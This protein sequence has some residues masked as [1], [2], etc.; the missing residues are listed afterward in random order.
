MELSQTVVI[1]E[2]E[3]WGFDIDQHSIIMC[4]ESCPQK[5]KSKANSLSLPV[6]DI[7]S[8]ILN[9]HLLSQN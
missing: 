4:L 7:F 3:I 2:L 6:W 5:H 9:I 1:E 8:I